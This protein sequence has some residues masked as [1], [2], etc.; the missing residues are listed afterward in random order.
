MQSSSEVSCLFASD[1][2]LKVCYDRSLANKQLASD[3][4]VTLHLAKQIVQLT[5]MHSAHMHRLK[6]PRQV[7]CHHVR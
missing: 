6:L 2:S 1:R 5:S 7:I 4:F 3:H